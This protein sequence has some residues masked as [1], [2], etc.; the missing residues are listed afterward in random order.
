MKNIRK[1]KSRLSQFLFITCLLFEFLLCTYSFQVNAASRVSVVE[2]VDEVGESAAAATQLKMPFKLGF[3][4]QENNGLCQWALNNNSVQKK[5]IFQVVDRE[6]GQALWELVIDTT[7]IEFVTQPF[8]FKQQ[9]LLQKCMESIAQS[10]ALLVDKLNAQE[11]VPFAQWFDILRGDFSAK[12]E[13][14]P[15]DEVMARVAG[16]PLRKPSA[17]WKPVFSPQATIQHPLEFTIPLYFCLFGFD[18]AS[19]TLPFMASLPGVDFLKHAMKTGNGELFWQVMNG[20][21]KNKLSGLMFLH[22]STLVLMGSEEDDKK[23]LSETVKRFNTVHQVDVKAQLTLMSRRTFSTMWHDS[24]IQG[25]YSD[26][27]SAMM[28]KNES[29]IKWKVDKLFDSVNYAEQIFTPSGEIVPLQAAVM[30]LLEDS[31]LAEN[32]EVLESLLSQGIIST[33]MVRHFK[34]GA[35][36]GGILGKDHF[37]GYYVR[38]IGSV[39]TPES[40]RLV[41]NSEGAETI[42]WGFDVLSPPLLLDPTNAMG[43]F[44]RQ[45]SADELRYGEAIVEVRAIRDVATR[46]LEKMELDVRRVGD[47]LKDPRQ[48]E[49]EAL[50]LFVFLNNFGRKDFVDFSVGLPYTLMDKGLTY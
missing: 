9:A 14:I 50:S 48:I 5:P 42:D 13:V 37:D 10:F 44:K 27:F 15:Q 2:E 29:Y 33:T 18:N 25:K 4:F 22:A 35:K 20:Y 32:S 21:T 31:F 26:F 19:Y 39:G 36:L 23:Q 40:S 28:G 12:Y 24:R 30:P 34:E 16:M 45:L 41:V 1:Q 49:S 47:F 38:S 3:E 17:D 6:T 43:F 8:S 46:F 11:E 7:D